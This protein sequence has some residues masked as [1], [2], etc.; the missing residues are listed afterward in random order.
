MAELSFK[1]RFEPQVLS[2]TPPKIW[3]RPDHIKVKRCPLKGEV[4]M[5]GLWQGPLSY[6]S[7][8]QSGEKERGSRFHG[9][10]KNGL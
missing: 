7:T 8:A 10:S 6:H 4:L 2:T 1:H 9:F 5:P 3:Y